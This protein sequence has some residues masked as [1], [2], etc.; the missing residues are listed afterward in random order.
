MEKYS[1]KQSADKQYPTRENRGTTDGNN[2]VS[3]K[4]RTNQSYSAEA[5][6]YAGDPG[7]TGFPAS[8]TEMD[9]SQTPSW[10]ST[11]TQRAD[12]FDQQVQDFIRRRPIAVM[13]GVLALG[14][15]ARKLM[16]RADHENSAKDGM[17]EAS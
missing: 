8:E 5:N 17:R 16:D 11:I 2:P 9:S 1:E 13:V 15:I 14:F 7:T 10:I 3:L 4:R 6:E 12:N